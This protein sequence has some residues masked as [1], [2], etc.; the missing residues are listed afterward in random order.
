MK[1][2]KQ[3][4]GNNMR[5]RKSTVLYWQIKTQ[6]WT[7]YYMWSDVNVT[8]NNRTEWDTGK[9]LSKSG[10]VLKEINS[11][12]VMNCVYCMKSFTSRIAMP[13]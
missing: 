12:I 7:V 10:V 11:G 1:N 9:V 6:F 2:T 13:D 4:D 8:A 5:I 3:Y